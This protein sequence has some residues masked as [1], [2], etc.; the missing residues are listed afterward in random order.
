MAVILELHYGKKLGLPEYS[1]HN[2]SVSLKT[3]AASLDQIPSEVERAYHILQESVD[4]QI[5]HPGYV[6]GMESEPASSNLVHMPSPQTN[7]GPS[8]TH[9]RCSLKQKELILKLVDER[10]LDRNEV[11][12]QARDRFGKGVV[13]LNKLEASGLIDELMGG[14]SGRKS[15]GGQRRAA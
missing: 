12:D 7:P 1:S 9:W 8:S 10:N 11:D 6:P 14:G 13:E 3:E 4:Q 5:I 15:R 2:F